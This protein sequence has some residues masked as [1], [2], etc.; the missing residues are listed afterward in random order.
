[1]PMHRWRLFR[2]ARQSCKTKRP[3]DANGGMVGPSLMIEGQPASKEALVGAPLGAG[4]TLS[5]SL[6]PNAEYPPLKRGLSDADASLET[7]QPLGVQ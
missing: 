7:I 6:G 1:M 4:L 2:D 5:E 3:G